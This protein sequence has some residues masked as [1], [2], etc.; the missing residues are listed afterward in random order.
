[1][2]LRASP[3]RCLD[4]GG[5]VLGSDI[6]GVQCFWEA[7]SKFCL[8]SAASAASGLRGIWISRRL[9]PLRAPDEVA[10]AVGID[11]AFE[12]LHDLGGRWSSVLLAGGGL[13]FINQADAADHVD[14][15]LEGGSSE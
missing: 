10:H 6:G 3:V 4:G 13:D 8:I 15:G 2:A 9:F 5:D 11:A 12:G 14:A 7:A 1:M